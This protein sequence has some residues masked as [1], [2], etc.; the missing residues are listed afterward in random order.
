MD[1]IQTA[2]SDLLVNLALGIISLLAAYGVAYIRK[3]VAKV[4]AQT[5]LL[6]DETARNLLDNALADVENLA[7]MTVGAFEQT[8]AQT[9]RDA[10]K[11]GK[12][13]REQ[14]TELGRQAFEEI[15]AAIQPEAQKIIADNLGDFDEYLSKCIENAVRQV[16]NDAPYITIPPEVLDS[17]DGSTEP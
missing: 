10:V 3:A 5:A 7:V 1:I 16:K 15:K 17:P 4:S 8:T 6:A 11:L 13:D 12:A 2:A 14:L 9:L